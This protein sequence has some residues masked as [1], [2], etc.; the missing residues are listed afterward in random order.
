MPKWRNEYRRCDNCRREYRLKADPEAVGLAKELIQAE[1]GKF[2]PEKLPDTYAATLREL[3]QAKV[4]QRRPQIEVASEGKA[5]K[6]VINIMVAQ[7]RGCSPT[8]G[9]E[10]MTRLYISDSGSDKNDGLTKRTPIYSWKRASRLAA[11]HLEISVDSA[12]TRKRLVSELCARHR[13]RAKT[14][15]HLLNRE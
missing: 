2:E 5:P 14:R 11:G 10:D 4:E 15:S 12:S 8:A 3:I 13:R 6:G 9:E 1:S 7:R